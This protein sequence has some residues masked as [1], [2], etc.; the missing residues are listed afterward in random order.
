MKLIRWEL[1]TGLFKGL[2]FGVRHYFFNNETKEGILLQEE[3]IVLY[4]GVVQIILTL[5]R[6]EK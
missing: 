2:L 6:I 5:I 3:D 4:L 1:K